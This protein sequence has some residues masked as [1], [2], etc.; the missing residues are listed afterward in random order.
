MINN[1]YNKKREQLLRL[2]YLRYRQTPVFLKRANAHAKRR[3][4]STSVL[5]KL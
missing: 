3:E 4:Q 5:E 1:R 2:R